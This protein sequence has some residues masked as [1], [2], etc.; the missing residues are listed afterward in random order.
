MLQGLPASQTWPIAA[1]LLSDASRGVRIKAVALLAAVPTASQAPADREN[2]ER[3]ATEFVVAQRVNAD[4]PE[5]RS[6]L[7]KLS[8]GVA[9]PPTPR[10]SSKLRYGLTRNTR[11]PRSI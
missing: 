3:A 2:F 8:P 5:A 7:G 6:S 11:R 4:R 10:T 1:P 9:W